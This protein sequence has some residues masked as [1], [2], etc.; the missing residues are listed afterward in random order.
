MVMTDE[1]FFFFD[2][3]AGMFCLIR[4]HLGRNR[5]ER[6]KQGMWISSSKKVS[7]EGATISALLRQVFSY[8][9]CFQGVVERHMGLV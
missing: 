2:G 8:A 3:V 4:R 9:W 6:K 7:L 5:N 1:A